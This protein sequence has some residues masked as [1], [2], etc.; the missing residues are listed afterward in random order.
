M[1]VGGENTWCWDC[2]MRSMRKPRWARA[3]KPSPGRAPR[4]VPRQGRGRRPGI[5]GAPRRRLAWGA[6]SPGAAGRRVWVA[7]F[8]FWV[9]RKGSRAWHPP[10]GSALTVPSPPSP[11]T[12]T[13]SVAPCRL[14]CSVKCEESGGHWACGS[15]ALGAPPSIPSPS[16]PC[17]GDM[18]ASVLAAASP[19]I[20]PL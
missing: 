15:S 6:G 2:V 9:S 10:R 18:G 14:S 8:P 17:A 5:P 11:A 12:L 13:S 20:C 3:P 19:G 4:R 1:C 16:P 7:G